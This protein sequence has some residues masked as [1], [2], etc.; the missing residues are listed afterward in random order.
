MLGSIGWRVHKPFQADCTTESPKRI[1]LN[2]ILLKDPYNFLRFP[3]WPARLRVW[4]ISPRGTP[5]FRHFRMDCSLDKAWKF[6]TQTIL[7]Q[8]C[9]QYFCNTRKCEKDPVSANLDADTTTLLP[10][11]L[12]TGNKANLRYAP[13][14]F[15]EAGP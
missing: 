13:I 2:I 9:C 14:S 5:L 1:N 4:G 8:K 7:L 6:R 12:T 10:S 11:S 3:A 15:L